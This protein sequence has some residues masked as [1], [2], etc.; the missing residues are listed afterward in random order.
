MHTPGLESYS[1]LYRA[2][3]ARETR[4]AWLDISCVFFRRF[5]P[6]SVLISIWSRDRWMLLVTVRLFVCFSVESQLR[7]CLSFCCAF[8]LPVEWQCCTLAPVLCTD[9]TLQRQASFSLCSGCLPTREVIPRQRRSQEQRQSRRSANF[10]SAA[11]TN[12]NQR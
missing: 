3:R 11:G 7:S 5:L 4:F 6:I 8:D 10:Q 1:V 9:M 12:E 2:I